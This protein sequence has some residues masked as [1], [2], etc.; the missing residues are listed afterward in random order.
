M[1]DRAM[2]SRLLAAFP[3]GVPV[4]RVPLTHATEAIAQFLVTPP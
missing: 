2:P 1:L 3:Q 4:E